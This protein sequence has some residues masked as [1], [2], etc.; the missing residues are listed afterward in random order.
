MKTLLKVCLIVIMCHA[1]WNF[2]IAACIPDLGGPPIV[3]TVF[4]N[5]I[6]A[7]FS[8]ALYYLLDR[9]DRGEDKKDQTEDE[10]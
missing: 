8:A 2:L 3:E 4:S 7:V 6:T 1:G 9:A 5:F 10:N